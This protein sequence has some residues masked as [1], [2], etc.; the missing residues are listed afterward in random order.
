M[1]RSPEIALL[2]NNSSL[3]DSKSVHVMSSPKNGVSSPLVLAAKLNN[4]CHRSGHK[5]SFLFPNGMN[6]TPI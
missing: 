2:E 1:P 5:T 6:R 3:N 4:D